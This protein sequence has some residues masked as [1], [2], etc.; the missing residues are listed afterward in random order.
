MQEFLQ[1]DRY[2]AII[3]DAARAISERTR[4][5]AYVFQGNL[6]FVEVMPSS[7]ACHWRILIIQKL[8]FQVIYMREIVDNIYSTVLFL[9]KVCLML[10]SGNLSAVV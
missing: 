8:N 9:D 7:D 5:A 3:T 10:V 6:D 2:T 1:L 4:E